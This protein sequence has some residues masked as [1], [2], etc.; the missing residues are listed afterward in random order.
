M[1]SLNYSKT[2]LG[3]CNQCLWLI[4]NMYIYHAL[5]A[6]SYAAFPLM[7]HSSTLQRGNTFSPRI[8]LLLLAGA[9][10]AT[11]FPPP[12]IQHGV[13]HAKHPKP[14][15]AARPQNGVKKIAKPLHQHS[16]TIFPLSDDH[17]IRR[18]TVT[19]LPEKNTA[20]KRQKR[21]QKFKKSGKLQTLHTNGLFRNHILSFSVALGHP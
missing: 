18:V 21:L 17:R 20:K 19:K 3:N 16:S 8:V 14:S 12:A 5:N 1:S 7:M 13:E 9:C 15:K 6:E 2:N 4:R 10:R 11:G